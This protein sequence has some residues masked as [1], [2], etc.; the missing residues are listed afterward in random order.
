MISWCKREAE[1]QSLKDQDYW[2]RFIIDEMKSRLENRLPF[3]DSS[4]SD[5]VH[6][7]LLFETHQF[8]L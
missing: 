6:D 7:T 4:L 8:K 3:R 1:Q 2:G 5:C